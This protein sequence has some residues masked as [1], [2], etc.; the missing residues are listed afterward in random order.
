MTVKVPLPP[1][2]L[3]EISHVREPS[4]NPVV[5]MS[6]VMTSCS[7]VEEPLVGLTSTQ[8]QLSLKE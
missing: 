6:T 8:P 1:F 2:E 5:S 3:M 7:P 4:D